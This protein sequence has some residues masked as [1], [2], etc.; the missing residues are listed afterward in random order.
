MLCFYADAL[1]ERIREYWDQLDRVQV[2]WRRGGKFLPTPHYI[3]LPRD[4]KKRSVATPEKGARQLVDLAFGFARE[5]NARFLKFEGYG[6]S[7]REETAKILFSL[8]CDPDTTPEKESEK[9]TNVVVAAMGVLNDTLAR[10]DAHLGNEH[11]RTMEAVGKVLEMAD[12]NKENTNAAIY[13]LAFKQQMQREHFEH[14]ER[15]EDLRTSHETTTRFVDMVGKPF[16]NVFEKVLNNVF[17][18]DDEAF[19]GK[20]FASRLTAILKSVAQGDGGEAKLAKLKAR[21]GD[22]AW[23]VLRAMSN[24]ASDDVFTAQARKFAE[25]LGDD[26]NATMREIM[27]IIGEGNAMALLRLL[28]DAGLA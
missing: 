22:D 27:G 20:T 25:M 2:F 14:E 23:D 9:Q 19:K 12:K 17:R 7:K 21:I 13:A 3:R 5:N 1:A 11:N 24:A 18:V 4:E 16:A 6:L 28:Q 10:M 26:P 15:M 8:Q